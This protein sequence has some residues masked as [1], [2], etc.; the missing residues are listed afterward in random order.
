MNADATYLVFHSMSYGT[1]FVN[2]F[3]SIEKLTLQGNVLLAYNDRR[4]TTDSS[5]I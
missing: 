5:R 3:Q 2:F 4:T 1:N